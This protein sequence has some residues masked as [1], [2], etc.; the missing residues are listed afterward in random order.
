MTVEKNK[1]E[2]NF[3]FSLIAAKCSHQKKNSPSTQKYIY[4]QS[5]NTHNFRP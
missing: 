1:A 3:R 4:F 2:E 5:Q